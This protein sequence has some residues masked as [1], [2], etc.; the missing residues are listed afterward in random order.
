VIILPSKIDG[1]LGQAVTT[2]MRE[3]EWFIDWHSVLD[4]FVN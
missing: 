3:I 2:E 1:M 4:V